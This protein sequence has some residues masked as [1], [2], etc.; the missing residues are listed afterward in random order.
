MEISQDSVRSYYQ[1]ALVGLQTV[2]SRRATGRRFG[3]D[4]D[5]RWKSFR[6]DLTTGDRMNVL[7][8]DADTEWPG[9]FGAR[10][11]FGLDGVAE[12]DAFGGGGWPGIEARVAEELWRESA[13]STRIRLTSLS[14]TQQSRKSN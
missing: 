14:R 7:I 5:A 8:R 2:E 11:A 4:A 3:P 6:G 10:A 13:R 9:A 1:A 12:D